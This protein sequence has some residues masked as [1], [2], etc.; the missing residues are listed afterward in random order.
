[1]R[2][3]T[4][5]DYE[6][7]LFFEAILWGVYGNW[8]IWFISTIN[9]SSDIFVST[10]QIILILLSIS[11]FIGYLWVSIVRP[12]GTMPARMAIFLH[13]GFAW[14]P[15]IITSYE[16]FPL[17]PWWYYLLGVLLLVFNYLLDTRRN[18]MRPLVTQPDMREILSE[19]RILRQTLG[20]QVDELKNE[21]RELKRKLDEEK[22]QESR[23]S[24]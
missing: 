6:R 12:S 8:L 24:P 7:L 21:V 11:S 13:I 19:M 5:E 18:L 9:F 10:V 1:M 15:Q 3:A 17:L 22:A 4:R 20:N 23:G 16:L 14:M 2:P